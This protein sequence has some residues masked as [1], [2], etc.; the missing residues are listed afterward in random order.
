LR[1][2]TGTD[3]ADEHGRGNVMDVAY[4]TREVTGK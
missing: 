2:R 1:L 4:A 3:F